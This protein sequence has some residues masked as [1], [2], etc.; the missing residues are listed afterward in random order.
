MGE[1]RRLKCL[2]AHRAELTP[3]CRKSLDLMLEI[4]DFGKKQEVATQKTLAK[5]AEQEKA[6]AAK[7][8]TP[9]SPPKEKP[10]GGK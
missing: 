2:G 3:A 5:E 7:K 9:A 10:P 1:G 4:Y 8:N 6:E